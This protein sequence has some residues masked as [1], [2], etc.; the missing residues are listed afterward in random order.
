MSTY[1]LVHGAWH[2]GWCWQRVAPL[3]RARG[4]EVLTPSLSG[5][6]EHAHML[7]PQITLQTHVADIVN[8]CE[9]YE[10][11]D[12]VLV[13]HSYGGLIITGAADRLHRSGSIARLV[14]VDALVPRDGEGW[15]AFHKPEQ[16]EARHASARGAG[17]GLC[18]PTAQ[19]SA[20]G[21]SDAKDL[22]WV[23]RNL[24]PH[25]YGT[26]L[27]PLALP[28]LAA[29][30]G[31]AAL[32]RAYIDC[33]LPF[34]SDFNGLKARLKADKSWKYVELATCHDAMVTM[35]KELTELLLAA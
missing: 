12:A 31:A 29:G 30:G 32:P 11:E 6:G 7:S 17:M 9:R 26:Y 10:V 18:L 19:A 8:L 1:I 20:F 25:P 35:P 15:S 14:Y 33:T 21:I 5:M 13:G 24:K 27:T 16:V 22:A 28:E 34:Y 2:G 4:H 3:L 23:D